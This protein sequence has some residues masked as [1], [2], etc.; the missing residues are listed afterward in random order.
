[1]HKSHGSVLETFQVFLK[2]G[3]TSFGGPVAHLGY[4]HREL[5]EKRQ[6]LDDERFAQLLALC[7]FLPGPASSQLGFSL[8][9]LRSGGWGGLAAFVGFTAPSALLMFLFASSLSA[10]QGPYGE[11]VIHG[12]KLVALAVVSN[13]V[14]GMS[15]KLCPDAV[16]ATL[17]AVSAAVVLLFGGLLVQ[18]ALIA[19]G[20]LAGQIWCREVAPLARDRTPLAYGPKV[21]VALLLVFAAF[22]IALPALTSLGGVFPAADG[23]YRAGALVFG[24]GHVVLPFLEQTVVDPG[25]LTQDE[26]LAGYGAAQAVP[27]PMFSLSVFLGARLPGELGGVVGAL[28][29]MVSLFLPGFLLVSGALPLWQ[30]LADRPGAAR[31]SAGMGAVV[32]GILVAALYDP[33]WTG[34]VDGPQDVAVALAGFVLAAAWRAPAWVVVLWCVLATVGL[35]FAGL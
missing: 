2:L 9:L 6:W 28:V 1:M 7:Q 29:A 34:A 25:W 24:G 26:F 21:G 15:R 20:A 10:L 30:R 12:L 4:F 3:L 18:L 8:G 14:L 27:G 23:F 22:L 32:L 35:R 13:A 5:V 11:A 17:T 33:V 16:R 19:G 31:A